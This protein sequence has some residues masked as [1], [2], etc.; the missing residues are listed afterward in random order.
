MAYTRGYGGHGM[1]NTALALP[2]LSHILQLP[3]CDGEQQLGAAP[4][5]LPSSKAGKQQR[6]HGMLRVELGRI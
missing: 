3:R 6:R 4:S 1:H 5:G 2:H